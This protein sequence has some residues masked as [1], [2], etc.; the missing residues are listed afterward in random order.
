MKIIS[1]GQT[2]V[3]RA[4]LDVGFE[5]GFETGGWCPR[6]RWAEDG[7][8]PNHYPLSETRA[9]DVHVRT[10]RNVESSSATLVL[11]RGSP[12]GGTRLTVDIAESMRR[13]L[14]VV[15]LNGDDDPVDQIVEWLV[16]TKPLILNVAGPRESGAPGIS[17]QTRT[18]LRLALEL[19][20]GKDTGEQGVPDG[21]EGSST[22][23]FPAAETSL[24]SAT[25]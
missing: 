1:G 23:P 10:Q 21:F 17:E 13:P 11:T 2:G 25:A 3:D 16:A 7:P 5:L 15:D 22:I 12:M 20:R 14:L 9:R 4:A 18:I 19:T 24:P 6:G 8:I